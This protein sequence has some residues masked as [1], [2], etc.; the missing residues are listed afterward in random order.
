MGLSI[1][2]EVIYNEEDLMK[3]IRESTKIEYCFAVNF[4][5]A[6][7]GGNYQ[8]KISLVRTRIPDTNFPAW[9]EFLK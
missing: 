7:H 2:G 1:K 9:S 8:A 4:M 3:K 5:K 6:K